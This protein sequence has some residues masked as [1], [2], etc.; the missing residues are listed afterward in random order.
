MNSIDFHLFYDQNNQPKL[1]ISKG[2]NKTYAVFL[3][4]ALASMLIEISA[5]IEIADEVVRTANM[6]DCRSPSPGD[7]S[8]QSPKNQGTHNPDS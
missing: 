1:S 2:F 4:K 5:R 7:A 8:E 3:N 6:D